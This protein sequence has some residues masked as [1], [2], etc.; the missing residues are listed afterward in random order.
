MTTTLPNPQA[1]LS[2]V[3]LRRPYFHLYGEDGSLYMGR[4]WAFG[5]SHPERDD[6]DDAQRTWKR[7][8]LDSRIGKFVAGRLH[9]LAREDRARDN[10]T[11]PADFISFVLWGWYKEKRPLDQKQHAGLDDTHYTVTHRRMFSIAYRRAEDRHTIIEVS[12]GGCW[13][14]VIWFRKGKTWGFWNKQNEF[15]P[16]KQYLGLP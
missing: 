14:F 4:W 6:R 10:H 12:E 7:H 11:H 5:G 9:L 2:R 8:A 3:F 13:T 15:I 16:W 1:P